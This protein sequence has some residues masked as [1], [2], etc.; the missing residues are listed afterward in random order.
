MAWLVY[1]TEE[2]ERKR[3][4]HGREEPESMYG[5]DNRI[6]GQKERPAS[7]GRHLEDTIVI[8]LQEDWESTLVNSHGRLVRNSKRKSDRRQ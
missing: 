2:R 5:I 8:W 7:N 1:G 3:E 6:A 4:V